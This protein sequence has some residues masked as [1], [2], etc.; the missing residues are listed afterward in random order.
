MTNTWD[1]AEQQL[2]SQDVTGITS[3]LWDLDG[4]KY[5]TQNPT[6]INLTVTLDPV[7]NR[8]VLQDN[9]GVTTYTRD[10]QSRLTGILN[11]YNEQTTMQ[12]DCLD[13]ESHRVLAN[14]GIISHTFDPAGRE[15]LIQNRSAAGVSSS[16]KG[17]QRSFL[18]RPLT[19][20]VKRQ[21]HFPNC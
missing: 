21:P 5:A 19:G 9:Y 13:R 11:P 17:D 2:T 10:I 20:P 8:L 7:G 14:G 4:R 12:W 15:T 3:L 16:P 6:G 18:P 1:S